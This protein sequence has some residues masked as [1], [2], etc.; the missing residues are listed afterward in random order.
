M[1]SMTVFAS[2]SPTIG[3]WSPQLSAGV[4]KQWVT[5]MSSGKPVKLNKPLPIISLNN[6]LQLPKGFVFTFDA[7]YMGEGDTQNVHLIKNN[8]E[9]NASITKSFFNDRLNLSL[10]GHD[11]FLQSKDG[12]LLYNAQMELYQ[13]NRYDSRQLEFTVRYRFNTARSKYK[14]TNAGESEINRLK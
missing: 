1:P 11:V 13:M 14:G 5:I 4:I 8:V 12:N 9:V 2:L 10:K 7:Q 3:V 6:S